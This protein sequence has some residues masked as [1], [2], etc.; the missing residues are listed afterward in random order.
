MTSRLRRRLPHIISAAALSFIVAVA[1]AGA[2]APAAPTK[3]QAFTVAGD[4]AAAWAGA[5]DAIDTEVDSCGMR[6]AAVRQCIVHVYDLSSDE[7]FDCHW[8]VRVRVLSGD[9]LG[10]R[11]IRH[12]REDIDCPASLPAGA[13]S[14]GEAT[15]PRNGRLGTG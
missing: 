13:P 3:A 11:A 14:A 1:A 7:G 6:S 9:R 5:L 4:V 8:K 10:W 12:R 15:V 2:Q